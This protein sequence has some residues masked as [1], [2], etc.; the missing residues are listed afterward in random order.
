MMYACSQPD[1][2]IFEALTL[3]IGALSIGCRKVERGYFDSERS[4]VALEDEIGR[5]GFQWLTSRNLGKGR[6]Q[7]LKIVPLAVLIRHGELSCCLT[8]TLQLRARCPAGAP[9]AGSVKE[10][11]QA[12]KWNV[13][14]TWLSRPSAA[15]AG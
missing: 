5:F 2:P 1:N 8:G 10:H 6:S 14:P 11:E 9:G 3:L 13:F 4:V 12:H 7:R 15:R